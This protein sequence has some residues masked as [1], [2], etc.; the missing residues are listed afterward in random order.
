[1]AQHVRDHTSAPNHYWRSRR[2]HVQARDPEL[3]HASSDWTRKK[4]RSMT[5][6]RRYESPPVPQ[7]IKLHSPL[8]LPRP[9]RWDL[10][11]RS[12]HT[13]TSVEEVSSSSSLHRSCSHV[14]ND[15]ALSFDDCKSFFSYACRTLMKHRTPHCVNKR[16]ISARVVTE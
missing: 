15:R 7:V 2:R 4:L 11:Y 12:I 16:P 14:L 8:P 1:V 13:G 9:V 10:Q 5:M 3:P 6:I